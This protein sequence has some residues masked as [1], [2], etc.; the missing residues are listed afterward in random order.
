M[1]DGEEF[2][3]YRDVRVCAHL[4]AHVRV[5]AFGIFRKAHISASKCTNSVTTCHKNG[6]ILSAGSISYINE[7]ADLLGSL[8]FHGRTKPF[9][10]R[11]RRTA[12]RK[13]GVL[14]MGNS[15][16]RRGQ[17][18]LVVD[19]DVIDI[20]NMIFLS[21]QSARIEPETQ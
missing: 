7:W 12:W 21:V 13:C 10:T 11:R 14:E 5:A 15:R 8:R 1:A 2:E 3:T 18:G 20:E 19:A 9:V 16:L 4:R 6:T 17:G